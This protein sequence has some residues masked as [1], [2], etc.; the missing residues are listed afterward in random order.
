L[1]TSTRPIARSRLVAWRTLATV[2]LAAITV[3]PLAA[4]ASLITRQFEWSGEDGY[5][6]N[7]TFVYDDAFAIVT[8]GSGDYGSRDGTPTAGLEELVIS[9]FDPD[10]ILLSTHVDVSGG[11]SSYS[12]LSFQFDTASQ[13]LFGFFDMGQDD[14]ITGEHYIAGEIGG[15]SELRSVE[16]QS[17][18]DAFAGG[19]EISV[20]PVIPEP[21]AALLFATGL[22]IVRARGRRLS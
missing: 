5:T 10:D 16:L 19:T 4:Q 17:V 8:H 7:G 12:Y 3:L 11:V 15:G 2:A 13:Q 9:F 22:L 18:L 20:S 21:G 6:A 14:Q 1:R